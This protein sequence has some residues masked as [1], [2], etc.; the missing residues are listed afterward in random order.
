MRAQL[1]DVCRAR[2]SSCFHNCKLRAVPSRSARLQRCVA[3]R[4]VPFR[5]VA[6]PLF[7]E[8][9]CAAERSLLHLSPLQRRPQTV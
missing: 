2:R 5:C 3:L 9:L 8:S 6:F 7:W 4:R 1:M